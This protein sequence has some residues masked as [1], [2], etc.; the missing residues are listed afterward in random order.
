[1]AKEIT[2]YSSPVRVYAFAADRYLFATHGEHAQA[3]LK[4]GKAT[5]YLQSG[6]MC[7]AIRLAAHTDMSAGGTRISRGGMRAACGMSQDYVTREHRPRQVTATFS[8]K[9]IHT[10]D[11][12]H[13]YQATNGRYGFK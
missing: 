8:F 10:A 13:F 9:P 2:Q 7:K 4:S 12:Q 1:M 5:V 6:V 3:L 11:L